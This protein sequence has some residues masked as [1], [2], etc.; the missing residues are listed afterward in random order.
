MKN[1]RCIESRKEPAE[2]EVPVAE[3]PEK[4]LS[5][6]DLEVCVL[7][8]RKANPMLT[9]FPTLVR[10]VL[11]PEAMPLRWL[12]T[13]FIMEARL[14][15]AKIPIPDPISTSGRSNRVKE[16][17]AGIIV[18]MRKPADETSSPSITKGL[19]PR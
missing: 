14:G 11:I 2:K 3:S 4:I 17:S 7:I 13:E 6:V 16:T 15:D 9:V 19:C 18:I 1:T 8:M 10:V 5:S 12:G